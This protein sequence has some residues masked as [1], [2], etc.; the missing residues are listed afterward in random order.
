MGR[1]KTISDEDLLAA[2]RAVFVKEGFGASTKQIARQAGVSE[3]VL[4]QRF[5]TKDEL[6]F[7][8]MVPPPAD[9]TAMFRG[10]RLHGRALIR[11]LTLA[12]LDY[13]RD[14]LPVLLPLMTH[15]GFRFEELAQRHPDS[16]LFVLRREITLFLQKEKEAGRLD[17]DPRGAALAIWSV[18]QS[19]AFFERLGAHGGKFAPEIL[20]WTIDCLW[21]GLQP[22]K[23][24]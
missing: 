22:K 4:Y 12:M 2:A 16:P 3:G 17:S 1:K 5:T 9:V 19:V 13:C 24:K 15:P 18:A 21:T 11:K 20:D 6:F 14:T 23:G 7:A 10:S 8:A